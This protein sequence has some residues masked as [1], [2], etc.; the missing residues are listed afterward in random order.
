[1][2]ALSM[3]EGYVLSESASAALFRVGL[4]LSVAFLGFVAGSFAMF[5]EA[6]PARYLADAYRG[7]EALLAAKTQYNSPYP[8]G[9]WQPARTAD[10]GVTIY[11]PA[12]ALNGYTLFTSGEGQ[13][14]ALIS[15]TGEVLHQRQLPFIAI[16]DETAQVKDPRPD[17]M[18]H[19]R[20]A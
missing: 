18:I 13:R 19:Y 15:M 1:M 3:K 10:R 8:V 12:K 17:S 7:G 11:N 6:W 2:Q 14:A 9:F 5:S 20:S 4:F 16:W